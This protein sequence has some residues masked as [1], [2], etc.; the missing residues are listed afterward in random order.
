MFKY[1]KKYWIFAVLAAAFM[2]AEVY[3]DMLQ[4]KLMAE[5]VDSGILGLGNNGYFSHILLVI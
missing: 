4:P 5:I 1:M 3:V 2:I